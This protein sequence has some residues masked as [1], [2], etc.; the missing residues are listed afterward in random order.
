MDAGKTIRWTLG[1]FAA[2][3]VVIFFA[4]WVLTRSAGFHRYLL[5]KIIQQAQESTGARIDIR[6]MDVHWSPLTADFYGVVVH[7]GEKNAEPALMTAD[8]LGV[9]LGIGELLHHSVDLY[10]LV[11]DKPVVHVL[12][13]DDGRNNLP[14]A[15]HTTAKSSSNTKLLVRHA[16]IRDGLVNYND[17][18]TPLSADLDNFYATADYNPVANKY[19]GSLGYRQGI[20][21]A[22]DMNAFAHEAQIDFVADSQSFVLSRLQISSRSSR[23]TAHA[24]LKDYAN[25]IVDGDYDGVI[26]TPELARTFKN[27]AIPA[28]DVSLRGKF[29][30]Q[31]QA[32]QAFLLGLRVVGEMN[33]PS[34][35]LRTEQASAGL[36]RVHGEYTLRDANLSVS[37]LQANVLDGTF[38][39]SFA[40]KNLDKTT[41]PSQL[42]AQLAG[43]SLAK[44]S[45]ALAAD[46][47]K[48][49]RLI[50]R[51]SGNV[52]AGW[53]TSVQKAV[54]HSHLEIH[55]PLTPTQRN[56][57]VPVNAI[58]NVD[59]DGAHERASFGQSQIRTANAQ[60]N[61]SGT[62]S[63]QSHL[64]IEADARDLHEL[65]ALLSALSAANRR[66]NEPA[67]AEYDL[68]GSAHFSGQISGSTSDPRLQGQLSSSGLQVQTSKWR[69]IRA[70]VDLSSSRFALQNVS[71]ENEQKGQIHLSARTDLQHWSFTPQSAFTA[72]GQITNFSAA[73]VQQLAKLNYPISGQLSGNFSIAGSEDHPNGNGRLDLGK[74][75]AWG[76]PINALTVEF[77]ATNDSVDSQTHLAINAGAV[78]V[79]LKY[80]PKTQNYEA[81]LNANGLKL[82][83]VQSLQQR[84]GGLSGTLTATVHGQG[85]IKDPQLSGN[86]KS[87]E[88]TVSGEKISDVDAQLNVAR[89]H[90]EFDLKST[91]EQGYVRAKG[92]VDLTG[93]YS[94]NANADV[95]ALPLRPMLARFF[96]AVAQELKGQTEI[97][98]SLKGP[99]KNPQRVEATVE[100]PTINAEYKNFQIGNDGP[101]RVAY[102]TGVV[103]IEKAA[104]KGTGANLNVHG[105]VPL[106]GGAPMNVSA[107]GDVDL[108]IIQAVSSNTEASGKIDLDV[109]ASGNL[110]SPA[111]QGQVRI[112]NAALSAEALPS[113]VS[114]VNGEIAISGNRIEIK[115]IDGS[116]GGGTVSTHGAIVYG[117]QP[118]LNVDLQAKSVRIRPDG[119]RCLLD[120]NLQLNGT[121]QHSMMSGQVIVDRLS[122]Q[123]GFDLST[124]LGQFSGTPEV[125]TPTAFENNMKLNVSVKSAQN[126]NPSS[127]QLSMEGSADL[128]VT[129]TAADPVV[130]GRIALTRGELF[131]LNKRFEVDSG[132]V[133]FA[134]PVRT[135]PV[136]NL[137]VKTTVEQYNITIHFTGPVEQL[138]TTYTSE[139][140][141]PQ[142]DIINLLAFGQTTAEK[143]SNASTPTSLGAESALAQGVAGQV[144]KGVQSATGLSQLTIDPLAGNSQNPG[145][146]VAVQQRVTGSILLSFSTDVT[147]TQRQTI[148]LQY[149]P[150]KQLKFSV[151]RDEYGGY[152]IDVRLHK[153]F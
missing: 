24:T 67:P 72:R 151:V 139:P 91:V 42:K 136:V 63:R 3:L 74:G 81:D 48:N 131:F 110:S 62:L 153:V 137:F 49:A 123:Q 135:E 134:N 39:G 6:R 38:S 145:A 150:K 37:K 4:G 55:G 132:T 13:S 23:I 75:S 2:A 126:L 33:S 77:R 128:N 138:K 119:V 147:S 111:V 127:S 84:A 83:R 105:V 5:G 7:G 79:H 68:R 113:A 92:G 65:N 54:M 52:E 36:T 89:E 114:G 27:P 121:P 64:Q 30:Y 104:I 22:K 129:G 100:V 125:R 112:E 43:L 85:T 35:L 70:D 45:D 41:S 26:A 29:N 103:T 141:L 97:H 101:I 50:G 25:P 90:A 47:R 115:H 9:S 149:Q 98:A 143:A 71:L 107:K 94:A 58:V 146:Q 31:G 148:E 124:F 60:L 152:G 15:P 14:Q 130:L 18:Q 8:H 106:Q 34:L 108:A 57:D 16:A 59:Y 133:A 88:L 1:G 32:G 120:G 53:S 87:A 66:P 44:L 109:Q 102:R 28:G 56:T 80:A 117:P 21:A 51:L 11:L 76:E 118:T 82:E 19:A 142:M 86:I 73:D 144:A 95:R 96:P 17:Q 93:E 99:L 69:N 61:L 122:F 20:V 78:D 12:V 40:M 140:S 116:V 10:S 46:T